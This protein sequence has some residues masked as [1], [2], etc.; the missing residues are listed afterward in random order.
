[1][2]AGEVSAGAEVIS[3]FASK[4]LPHT[5]GLLVGGSALYKNYSVA[6]LTVLTTG[7][8][9]SPRVTDHSRDRAKR[10]PQCH[11]NAITSTAFHV[12]ERR[13]HSDPHSRGEEVGSTS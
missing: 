10:K 5:S 13:D 9:A 2:C 1:M 12:L 11:K 6:C 4:K 3:G 8:L 7:G